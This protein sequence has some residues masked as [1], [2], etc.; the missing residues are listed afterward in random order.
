M[1]VKN[2]QLFSNLNL[3]FLSTMQQYFVYAK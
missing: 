2:T 3:A 1:D